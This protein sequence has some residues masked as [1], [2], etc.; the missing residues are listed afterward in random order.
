MARVVVADGQMRQLAELRVLIEHKRVD[1]PALKVALV[2][3][4]RTASQGTNIAL[5]WK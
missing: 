1:G 4:K 3:R 2:G 5:R